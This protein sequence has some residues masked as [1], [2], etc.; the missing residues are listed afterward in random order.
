MQPAVVERVRDLFVTLAKAQRDYKTYP[1]NNPI[2]IKRR[3]E[4]FGKFEQVLSEM[5]DLPLKV[6]TEELLFAD[7]PIYKSA[8]RRESIAFHLYRHGVREIRFLRGIQASEIDGFIDA[9]NTDFSAEELDDDLITV[10]WTRDL[11]HFRYDAVD[12]VDP[13]MDWV[14]DPAGVLRQYLVAQREMPGDDKFR[15]VLNLEGGA[16]ARDPRGDL[17]AISLSQEEVGSLHALLHEDSRRDLALQVIDILTRVLKETTDPNEARNLLR[18]LERVVDISIDLRNFN[19]AATTL[20]VLSELPQMQAALASAVRGTIAKFGEAKSVKHLVDVVSRPEPLPGE[21]AL[22]PIDELDLFR[23]LIQLTKAAVVPLAEAMGVLQDRRIR[24]VFCEAIAELAKADVGLLAG[25]SR[26]NRWFV[27]RNV[28]YILG[29]TKNPDSLKILR[30]LAIHPNER[31]R[32]EAVRAAAL[33]GPGAKDIVQRALTD[34]DRLV[35]LL[36]YDLAVAFADRD[37]ATTLL[38]ILQDREFDGRESAEKRA[39]CLALARIAGEHALQPLSKVLVKSGVLGSKDESRGAA[40]AGIA[41]IGTETSSA[42]LREGARSGDGALA[43][44]C[45]QAL[46]EAKLE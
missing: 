1:R 20:R 9:I 18:I 2:L 15:N 46:R 21:P 42:Y 19:R 17:S 16:P 37:T 40:A 10:L 12:D 27:A 7:Q 26:D 33:M 8:D 41:A 14:R 23:Y 25:L 22:V 31:V 24:K 4:L 6:Q 35:R 3:E 5:D 39:V 30:S 28:A 13:R 45:L 36:A 34:G 43:A 29:L 11:P 32:A 38:G 44:I